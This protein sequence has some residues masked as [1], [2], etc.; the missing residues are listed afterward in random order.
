MLK[1]QKKYLK[2][3]KPEITKEIPEIPKEIPKKPTKDTQSWIQT[4]STT[5]PKRMGKGKKFLVGVGIIAVVFVLGALL[6]GDGFLTFFEN[7]IDNLQQQ[8]VSLLDG[9]SLG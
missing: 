4:R 5:M 9:L 6:V 8:I 7:I 1:D 2:L 3:K